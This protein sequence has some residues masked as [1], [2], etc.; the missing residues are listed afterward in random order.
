M[1]GKSA[2]PGDIGNL[3]RAAQAIEEQPGAK[4]PTLPVAVHGEP[5]QNEQR[6]RIKA[7]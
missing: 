4:T 6:Y 1:D 2:R 7:I 3:Q 5:R